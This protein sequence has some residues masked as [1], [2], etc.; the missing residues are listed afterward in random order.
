MGMG[1]GKKRFPP[2]IVLFC[3]TGPAL[4]RTTQ[5]THDSKMRQSLQYLEDQLWAAGGLQAQDAASAGA[6][7]PMLKA[8]HMG[9]RSWDRAH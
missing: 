4:F 6:S 2:K 9:H 5:R 1:M 8:P 3:Q 7:L